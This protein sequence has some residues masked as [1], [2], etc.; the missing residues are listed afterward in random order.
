[1]TRKLILEDYDDAS[2]II[3]GTTDGHIPIKTTHPLWAQLMDFT[4]S[5]SSSERPLIFIILEILLCLVFVFT[6]LE[7]LAMAV[8]F[9]LRVVV[10]RYSSIQ[11]P[12][13]RKNRFVPG[14][15]VLANGAIGV[16]MLYMF[17]Q[18]FH[19][20]VLLEFYIKAVHICQ[21]YF[22]CLIMMLLI[23][24]ISNGW[25]GKNIASMQ[26]IAIVAAS[27]VTLVLSL[28]MI[29][30]IEGYSMPVATAIYI[31]ENLFRSVVTLWFL[32]ILFGIEDENA[33]PGLNTP[34]YEEIGMV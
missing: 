11:V 9:V 5:L 24:I 28:F 30:D 31:V 22:L 17:V 13:A 7:V 34:L 15:I 3:N 25:R 26:T 2:G 20:P 8:N 27:A 14:L 23:R 10:Q 18:V 16:M 1:M 4:R 32:T 19:A 29:N 12:A 6:A 21:I 33:I